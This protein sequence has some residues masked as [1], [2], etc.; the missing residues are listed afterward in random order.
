MK[1]ID[2]NKEDFLKIENSFLNSQYTLENFQFSSFLQSY[3]WYEFQKSLSQK[4]FLKGIE[5]DSKLIG[6]FLVIEKKFLSRIK[7]WYIPRGPIFFKN[8]INYSDLLSEFSVLINK[9]KLF[10]IR[11]EPLNSDFSN[12][13]QNHSNNLKK[14][15]SIQ[16]DKTSFLFLGLTRDEILKKMSQK[17]RYNI[18]LAEK[19]GVFIRESNI[20]NF[21]NFWKLISETAKRD[22]FFI[23]SKDYY[24]NLIKN[25]KNIKIFEACFSDKVL[26]V[27]IFSFYG[28][29]VSYLHGASSNEM[30]NLMAPHALQWSIIEKAIQ[31]KF[32]FYDF[33][34]I[35]ELKWPGVSKFKAGFSGEVYK[36][37]GTFDFF[38]D[39]KKYFFYKKLRLIRRLLKRLI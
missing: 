8:N 12:F 7:Y 18:R 39:F 27:G 9:E 2:L 5:D 33:Y 11:F 22:N 21:E 35:D 19:K 14:T 6:F 30:R 34:G 26:A 32:L 13:Y 29:L 17:T 25:N 4:V 20:S 38:V 3:S 1:I 24:Y 31:E 16:P 28:P 37:P 10:F 23:H 15:E 36:F